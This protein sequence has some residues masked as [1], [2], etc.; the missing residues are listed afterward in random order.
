MVGPVAP[1][2]AEVKILLA[3]QLAHLGS[4]AKIH[5]LLK[6]GR[7]AFS[8]RTLGAGRV[9]I[10]WYY[11]PKGASLK[12]PRHKPKPELIATATARFTSSRQI[13]LTIKLTPLG[14]RMLTGAK[15]LKL[16]AQA[17]YTPAGYPK[18]LV[19]KRFTLKR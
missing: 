12:R 7:H 1:S 5:N 13:K 17:T 16:T 10:N 18:V 8:F 14:R 11:L 3:G 4:A 15:H 6:R 9:V 19:T 2:V